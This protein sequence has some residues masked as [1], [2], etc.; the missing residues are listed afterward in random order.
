MQTI[1]FLDDDKVINQTVT[2]ELKAA[3]GDTAQILSAYNLTEARKIWKEI[4]IDLLILDIKLPDGDGIEFA[5][6]V[7]REDDFMPIMVVSSHA[8]Y[9][10]MKLNN[11]LD[12]F[13]GLQKPIVVS[14]ILPRIKGNLKK[15]KL[16]ETPYLALK[17]G[18]I[19]YRIPIS[20]VIKSETI[21]GSKRIELTLYDRD[22]EEVTFQEF[23]MQSMEDFMKKVPDVRGLIRVNQ[24]TAVN[25]DYV[26]HYDGALNEL[27]LKHINKVSSIGVTFREAAGLLFGRMK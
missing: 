3:L 11:E 8:E 26:I 16:Q 4:E 6:E 20:K 19:R 14:E 17:D 25:P 15:V 18:R 9:L 22:T 24:S 21:K 5:R 13:L 10:D 2:T 12:L 23:P 27:H 1:L 7:R